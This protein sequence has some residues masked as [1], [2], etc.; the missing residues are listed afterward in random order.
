MILLILV[1]FFIT[2]RGQSDSKLLLLLQISCITARSS[3]G[4]LK[5]GSRLNSIPVAQLLGIRV[6]QAI[7]N[8][9]TV[10]MRRSLT[11]T[12]GRAQTEHQKLGSHYQ[13]FELFHHKYRT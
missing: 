4:C 13:K 10:P 8:V 2:E 11:L 5:F 6:T 1:N 9:N 7:H 12:N 3:A